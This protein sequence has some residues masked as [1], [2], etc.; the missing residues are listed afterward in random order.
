MNTSIMT[1][2]TRRVVELVGP[3][4]LIASLIWIATSSYAETRYVQT[5]LVSDLPGMAANT[6]PN[7]KNP[8]GIASSATS[9]F[10]VSDNRT[11]LSTLYN[12]SGTPLS[13]VVT[14]P[15][16]PGGAPPGA[17]TGVVF[18]GTSDFQIPGDGPARFIFGTENGT[19]AGWAS[20]LGTTAATIVDNSAA[21]AVYKGITLGNNGANLL[22]AANFGLGRID[23]FDTHFMPTNLGAG[24]FVDPT[25]PAGF[26]P[27]NVQNL[28]GTLYVTYALKEPGG[29]DDVPGPGNGFIDRFDTSGNLLNRLVSQG[30]LNSPWGLAIAPDSFGFFANDLL[31]GNFGD[32]HINAFDPVTGAFLGQ[33]R[34]S[35]GNPI[36][37]DGLW[38]LRVGNGGN[39]GNPNAV[40]FTAGINDEMDGLFGSLTVPDFGSTLALLAFG[41]GTVLLARRRLQSR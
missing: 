32:G 25:L 21:G 34:D 39:G 33:L 15:P 24:S 30:P 12:S 29:E 31:V 38:A 36:V 20:A 14:I 2:F 9:P 5:N 11:G 1:Y 7:L 41:S 6:D 17:P 19:I 4:A 26:S 23:V 22:Y 13:L 27:F 35:A 18:N 40:F 8:W 37:I 16:E 3:V 28:G 10:W